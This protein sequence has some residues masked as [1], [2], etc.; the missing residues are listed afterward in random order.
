MTKRRLSQQT[1]IKQ[2]ETG[3]SLTVKELNNCINKVGTSI[4]PNQKRNRKS[5]F[6]EAADNIIPAINQRNETYSK[7]SNNPSEENRSVFK[8]ASN[9]LNK[10]KR[11]AIGTWMRKIANKCSMEKVKV[12]PKR[13][14]EVIREI[15]EGLQGHHREPQMMKM[16]LPNGELATNN[17]QNVDV[18]ELH[19]TK[20]FNRD[21]APVDRSI[22]QRIKK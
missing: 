22:L 19:S 17:E 7:W 15:Q 1:T 20:V 16:A 9:L 10:L 11:T 13:A 4:I 14:W 3:G 12:N 2:A 8:I 18:F 5:W 6:R 21:D